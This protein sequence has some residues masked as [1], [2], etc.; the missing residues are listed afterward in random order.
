MKINKWTIVDFTEDEC[1]AVLFALPTFELRKSTPLGRCI[2]RDFVFSDFTPE[3]MAI[4][5]GIQSI[6][7]PARRGLTD[8]SQ[9]DAM[10]EM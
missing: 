9:P 5:Q 3:Q 8:V 4:L 1:A 6:Y 7:E 10:K 2:V